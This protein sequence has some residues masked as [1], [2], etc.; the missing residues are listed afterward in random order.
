MFEVTVSGEFVA[1]HQLRDPSGTAEPL[2]EHTWRVTLTVAGETLD[3]RGLL[4]DFSLL[5]RRLA[6]VLA[7]FDGHTLNAA[8][9]FTAQNPSAENVAVF[10]FQCLR[11]AVPRPA[12]L[13]SVAVEE[14]PGCVARCFDG[15]PPPAPEP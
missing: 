1:A 13:T 7:R 12:R 6:D 8:P 5:R 4:V 15:P 10:I 14:E 11:P 9:P 3:E 2:H